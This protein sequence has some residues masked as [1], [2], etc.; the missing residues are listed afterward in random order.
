MRESDLFLAF[1]LH[2]SPFSI[3]RRPLVQSDDESGEHIENRRA[4]SSPSRKRAKVH[5]AIPSRRWCNNEQTLRNSVKARRTVAHHPHRPVSKA[6]RWGS[7]VGYHNYFC[8]TP[9]KRSWEFTND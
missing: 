8:Q 4:A 7:S 3:L 6:E 5:Q 9:L 2:I 1:T